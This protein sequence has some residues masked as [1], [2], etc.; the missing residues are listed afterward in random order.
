MHPYYW[1]R[2]R[3]VR[4][5]KSF[6][7]GQFLMKTRLTE[8]DARLLMHKGLSEKNTQL[9]LM[10]KVEKNDELVLRGG[11]SFL[12]IP[13]MSKR[14]VVVHFSWLCERHFRFNA[15]GSLVS[16]WELI[17]PPPEHCRQAVDVEFIS[18]YFPKSGK[19]LKMWTSLGEYCRFYKPD[20][21][22]NL[23]RSENDFYD[24]SNWR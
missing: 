10:T 11:I 18:Y 14:G 22:D 7:G 3:L 16:Q 15:Q 1:S 8:K 9:I 20:D 21:P 6:Q 13:D 23:V 12:D 24:P 2:I 17:P 4:I 19:R 5:L